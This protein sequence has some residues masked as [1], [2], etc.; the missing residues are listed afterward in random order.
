MGGQH[1]DGRTAIGK[2][3]MEMIDPCGAHPARQEERLDEMKLGPKQRP[4]SPD[5]VTKRKPPRRQKTARFRYQR[6]KR[7]CEIIGERAS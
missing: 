2:M 1:A 3:T 5:P 4:Q 7:C 6:P